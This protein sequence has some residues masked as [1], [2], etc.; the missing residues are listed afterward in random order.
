MFPRWE[1]KKIE[2]ISAALVSIDA[3]EINSANLFAHRDFIEVLGKLYD[4]G[5]SEAIDTFF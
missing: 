1:N 2:N 3:L 5:Y 4:F